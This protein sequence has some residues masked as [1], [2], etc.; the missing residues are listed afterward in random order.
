MWMLMTAELLVNDV[1]MI[2]NLLELPQCRVDW[3]SRGHQSPNQSPNN[4]EFT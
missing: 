4:F 1:L 3:V 2:G